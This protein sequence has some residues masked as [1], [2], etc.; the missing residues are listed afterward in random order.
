M[1]ALPWPGGFEKVGECLY[2]YSSNGLYYARI[3]K[4]G[5]EIQR[6]LETDLPRCRLFTLTNEAAGFD[7]TKGA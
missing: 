6:S 3:K 2:R 5:K 4:P 7:Q 1:N